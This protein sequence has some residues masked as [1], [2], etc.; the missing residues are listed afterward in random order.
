M[1]AYPDS[2]NPD[3]LE[4]IPLDAAD[5]LDVGCGGA[6]LALAFSRLNPR[7]RVFGVDHDPEVA[8]LASERC[9]AFAS[10]DVEQDP[11]PFGDQKFDCIIYG[12]VLEHMRSPLDVVA[13]QLSSL[14][15]GGTVL[16]C[17]PNIEHWSF[18]FRLLSGTWEY[19]P[20][21]LF[22]V[23]H[24]R[25]FSMETMRRGLNELGLVPYDVSPR[26]FDRERGTA[27][28]EL[29]TPV[30][31]AIG[32]EPASYANR[33]APLQYIWRARK[34]VPARL[35]VAATMLRPV[36]GVSD[37]RVLQPQAALASDPSVLVRVSG[38]IDFASPGRD[39]PKVAVLHRP[40]LTGAEGL[41]HLRRLL[42]DGWV[43]VTE[44]D[45]HPDFF[46][47]L[48]GEELYTFAGVHAVQTTTEP[49]AEILRER[50]PELQ[51]FP[52]AI[53]MLPEMRNF[54]DPERLTLF[55][56]ALNREQDWG[57]LLP[58]LNAVAEVAGDRLRF[59]VVHDQALFDALATPHKIFTPTCDHPTYMRLLGECEISFMPLADTAFNRMK[60]DLK[61]IEAAACRVAAV[62]SR[63]VYGASVA[64]GRT[65]VLFGDADELYTALLRLISIPATARAL[66]DAARAYVAEDRML[67]YQV[68]PRI[69]W[70]RSLW[71][72]RAELTAALLARV[73][74][75]AEPAPAPA[76]APV[77]TPPLAGAALSLA[78]GPPPT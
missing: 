51:V 45:D 52:N 32:V 21:G 53:R 29:L 35:T 37:L 46:P 57:P 1:T 10:V 78:G 60:S 48:R 68:A 36:G 75:L 24:L 14:A 67:A 77:P 65:G 16:V 11:L 12:D 40:I 41:S 73:P 42:A 69:A 15:D 55:F 5:I 26:V 70:Y 39:E 6:S 58:V 54:T 25:W 20:Q 30:L 4:R 31:R 27:F 33:A 50:N 63:T 43:V 17:A 2:H 7:A 28:V 62:A 34:S 23:T 61:F 13:R 47:A 9:H 59:S 76:P 56:G 49:L 71:A 72:R 64:D 66:G 74:A 18:V 19:E 38:K 3:L 8:A 44:F 22:D